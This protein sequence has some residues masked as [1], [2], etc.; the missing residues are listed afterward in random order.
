MT[1]TPLKRQ[2]KAAAKPALQSAAR[3]PA[4][5]RQTRPTPNSGYAPAATLESE[6]PASSAAPDLATPPD[7]AHLQTKLIVGSPN[8]PL[9]READ[10]TAAEVV[11]RIQRFSTPSA[12]NTYQTPSTSSPEQSTDDNMLLQRKCEA[13][14][15]EEED[16]VTVQR[17]L[18]HKPSAA[19][20]TAFTP[21]PTFAAELRRARAGHGRA[22]DL[23]LRAPMER[24]FDADFSQVKVHDDTNAATLAQQVHARAFTV[25]RDVFFDRDEYNPHTTVGQR[26]LA[27]ELTHVL[28]QGGGDPAGAHAASESRVLQK[29]PKN[30]AAPAPVDSPEVGPRALMNVAELLV[31]V[32]PNGKILSVFFDMLTELE[33]TDELVETA[34]KFVEAI[35]NKAVD[36]LLST[37]E[38]RTVARLMIHYARVRP[39]YLVTGRILQVEAPVPKAAGVTISESGFEDNDLTCMDRA[40]FTVKATLGETNTDLYE[41]MKKGARETARNEA[42]AKRRRELLNQG[43][44]Q[45]EADE[46]VKGTKGKMGNRYYMDA[47]VKGGG[48]QYLGKAYSDDEFCKSNLT[49]DGSDNYDPFVFEK[50]LEGLYRPDPEEMMLS[51]ISAMPQGLY[52]FNA[53]VQ[54][55]H[56]VTF[57]IRKYKDGPVTTGACPEDYRVFFSDQYT[58]REN[59]PVQKPPKG[60]KSPRPGPPTLGA[61]MNGDKV[62]RRIFRLAMER[63]RLPTEQ[64]FTNR[65]DVK[66]AVKNLNAPGALGRDARRLVTEQRCRNN[67]G[68]HIW[69]ILP[70]APAMPIKS[71]GALDFKDSS[72]SSPEDEI[73]IDDD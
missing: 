36:L 55:H 3:K 73:T 30:N 23:S 65:A 49:Y 13:C 68:V 9:E 10:D 39:G 26:L 72:I 70:G 62:R 41:A 48:A 34:I 2:E 60:K 38:G 66:K 71:L 11:S 16:P 59:V 50:G 37:P 47:L 52:V 57:I 33:G 51:A 17:K 53:S 1:Y 14:A 12:L 27:H 56:V 6:S 7:V 29:A 31:A 67:G 45:D 61:E 43:K 58:D 21:S 32:G 24:G 18:T 63:L 28:Q 40:L 44:S 19:R 42:V 5:T 20:P 64:K 15:V 25:G 35:P 54:G 46:E 69:L 4:A 8:D 22:L